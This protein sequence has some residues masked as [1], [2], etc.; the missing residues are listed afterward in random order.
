VWTSNT[1]APITTSAKACAGAFSRS[2]LIFC[3]KREYRIAQ[4][5]LVAHHLSRKHSGGM[6]FGD[7]DTYSEVSTESFE[8]K[9]KELKEG[10]LQ[11]MY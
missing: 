6:T 7:S 2:L 11:G 4:C 8:Q 3:F 5:A 9:L 1:P 10:V